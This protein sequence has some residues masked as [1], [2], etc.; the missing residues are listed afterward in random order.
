MNTV[1]LSLLNFCVLRSVTKGIGEK[2]ITSSIDTPIYNNQDKYKLLS[3]SVPMF[4]YFVYVTVLEVGVCSF[5]RINVI[6]RRRKLRLS[7]FFRCTNNV[8]PHLLYFFFLFLLFSFYSP[9]IPQRPLTSLF[10]QSFTLF[11]FLPFLSTRG[12]GLKKVN[13]LKHF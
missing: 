11:L 2:Q 7:D 5:D 13:C 3:P 6:R 9:F 12:F 10:P 4:Y 1:S 8:I